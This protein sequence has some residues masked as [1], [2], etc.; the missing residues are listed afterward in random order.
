V[1]IHIYADTYIYIDIYVLYRARGFQADTCANIW[2]SLAIKPLE[3]GQILNSS[4]N[5]A[6]SAATNKNPP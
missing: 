2:S 4:Q 1:Y 3:R 5:R 6:L